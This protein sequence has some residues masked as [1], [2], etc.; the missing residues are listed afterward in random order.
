M[1]L[2]SF[3]RRQSQDIENWWQK[4]FAL[5]FLL[6]VAQAKERTKG[7]SFL[8]ST[9]AIVKSLMQCFLTESMKTAK[10]LTQWSSK[11]FTHTQKRKKE[12]K[13]NSK[14]VKKGFCPTLVEEEPSAATSLTH[15]PQQRISIPHA[16]KRRWL[17]HPFGYALPPSLFCL[18]LSRNLVCQLFV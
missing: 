2:W 9:A 12:R 10:N 3:C 14:K 5:C 17:A 7:N 11:S 15:H 8:R 4:A 13:P 6:L 1:P 18:S 16:D